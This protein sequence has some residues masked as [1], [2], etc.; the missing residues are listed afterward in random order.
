MWAANCEMLRL[1]VFWS[2]FD[3]GDDAY[4]Y[5]R[6]LISYLAEHWLEILE[7][8]LIIEITVHPRAL[9]ALVA[10]YLFNTEVRGYWVKWWALCTWPCP[11]V[12]EFATYVHRKR[13]RT[14]SGAGD[15]RWISAARLSLVWAHWW[16]WSLQISCSDN[17]MCSCHVTAPSEI[18]S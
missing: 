16:F 4:V 5:V 13:N 12:S 9:E 8:C 3:H 7:M 11:I 14:S 2:S 15:H 1:W 10:V 18:P 17:I 6:W